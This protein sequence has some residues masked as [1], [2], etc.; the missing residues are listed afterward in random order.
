MIFSGFQHLHRA[1]TFVDPPPGLTSEKSLD[2]AGI[3]IYIYFILYLVFRMLHFA[4]LFFVFYFLLVIHIF[5]LYFCFFFC[6]AWPYDAP[7]KI[8]VA[9]E[10]K[11]QLDLWQHEEKVFDITFLL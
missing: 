6:L 1:I 4:F 2:M 11:I 9:A 10:K 3:Y 5:Y 7:A 8:T